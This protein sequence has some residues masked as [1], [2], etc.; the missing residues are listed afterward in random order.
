MAHGNHLM[1]QSVVNNNDSNDIT[2]YYVF[3]DCKQMS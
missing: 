1:L 3:I 2:T